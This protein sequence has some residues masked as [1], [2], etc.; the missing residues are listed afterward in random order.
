MDNL[1]GLLSITRMNRVPNPRIRELCGLK[2]SLD[3]RI[4]EGVPQWFG[5]VGVGLGKFCVCLLL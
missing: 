4:D 2:K 3:E 1:K 5:H